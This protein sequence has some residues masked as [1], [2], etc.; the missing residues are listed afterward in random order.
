MQAQTLCFIVRKASRCMDERVTSPCSVYPSSPRHHGRAG[1][2]RARPGGAGASGPP[3]VGCFLLFIQDIC[4][5]CP[6]PGDSPLHQP[7]E[8]APCSV[9]CGCTSDAQL[10]TLCFV[11]V[12]SLT[13]R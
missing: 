6:L 2:S 11:T 9:Y 4:I 5:C 13:A 1:L 7:V 12:H 10:L 8:D 3:S